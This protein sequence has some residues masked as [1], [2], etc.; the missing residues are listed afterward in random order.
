VV[1]AGTVSVAGGEVEW[2][3]TELALP[4]PE[5]HP[6]WPKI[7]TSSAAIK[8]RRLRMSIAGRASAIAMRCSAGDRC[9][10]TTTSGRSTAIIRFDLPCRIVWTG[11]PTNLGR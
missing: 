3:A 6:V 4:A 2:V 10:A 11:L 1:E 7:A 8:V 9:V 5:A